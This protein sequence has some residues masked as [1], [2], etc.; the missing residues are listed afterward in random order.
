MP[1]APLGID[2]PAASA[3]DEPTPFANETS[4]SVGGPWRA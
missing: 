2:G 4:G 3:A 1:E